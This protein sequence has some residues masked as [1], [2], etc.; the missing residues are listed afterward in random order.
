VRDKS[1]TRAK[2]FV[3]DSFDVW[4]DEWIK[5]VTPFPDIYTA[6]FQE[7]IRVQCYRDN[8]TKASGVFK[9]NIEWNGPEELGLVVSL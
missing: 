9:K 7:W 2:L 8:V 1:L 4:E 3:L 5:F 6:T